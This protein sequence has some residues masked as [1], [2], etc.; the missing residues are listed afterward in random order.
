MAAS[1]ETV[2]KMSELGLRVVIEKEAGQQSDI[3]DSEFKAAGATIA[4]DPAATLKGA[5][6]VLKVQKPDA[7]ELK[8]LPKG[9]MLIAMLNPL[10]EKDMTAKYAKQGVNAF[11][12]EMIPR[13]T[14]AQSMDVLSSQ[15]NLAGY[16]A[17]ID[18]A[19]E[20]TRAFPMM[21]T[22]AGTVVPARVLILGAGVAGLQAIAT[23]KRLGAIV[24][25]FDVRK[26]AK[27][28]VES[29]GATFVEVES[30][31]DAETKGGYAKETS[32]AYQKRQADR[33]HQ[34]LKNSDIA[35]TTA[36]IPGKRA[37]TLIT[38][39]MVKDMQPGSII[40]DMAAVTGGNCALTKPGEVV[41]KYGVK[42]LGHTNIPSRVGKNA[43]QL[44]AR[45]LLNLLKLIVDPETKKLKLDLEDEIIKSALL[46]YEGKVL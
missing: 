31:E 18:A 11:A 20:F 33:I 16:R 30:D 21:M 15:S 8:L 1:P 44:Y 28:Q 43:S 37:P 22:A 3:P 41:K 36:L 26:V 17:I 32:K 24:S 19:A 40:V 4:K 27:E 35:V 42:I 10:V 38:E 23:A 13:I 25:A 34:S 29:L 9:S 46:T 7:S 12:L 14:R 2:K 6:I 39:A 45:N 5:S